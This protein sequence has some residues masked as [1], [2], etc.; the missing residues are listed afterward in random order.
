MPT[1]SQVS[2]VLFGITLST[3]LLYLLLRNVSPAEL[4]FHL[5]RTYW[6]WLALSAALNLAMLWARGFRWGWLFYPAR[7]SGWPL[8]SATTI[9]FMANNVLPLRMGELVRGYLAARSGGLSFWTALATLAVERALDMLSIL[10]VLGAVVFTVPVPPWLQAGALTFLALDLLAMGL[11]IFLARG[12]GAVAGWITRLPRFGETV[13]RWLALFATG[14]QSLGRGPHLVPLVGWTLLI[15]TLN[16]GSVWAALRA[17]GLA[18]PS[19]APLTVL[20]FA[21]IGVSIPSAPGFIG[22]LHFFVVQAL[23]IYAVTG[24][25]AV[26]VSFIYHAAGYVPVTLLGWALLMTRGVSL[27]EASREARAQAQSSSSPSP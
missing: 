8:V 21:G 10:L 9:G 20:A 17:G 15:W 26:S 14:L 23:A 16:A 22:T 12:R 25:E 6:R 3:G 24:A 2:R 27:W 4:L 1:R 13:T 19:S 11:L 5:G 7:Q 18:L